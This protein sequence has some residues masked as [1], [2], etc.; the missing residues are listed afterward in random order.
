MSFK[1][2]SGF[3]LLALSCAVCGFAAGNAPAPEVYH[4]K[5]YGIYPPLEVRQTGTE[6]VVSGGTFAYTVS[7]ATGQIV[8]AEVLG[9][10]FIAA[11]SCFPNPYV[12]LMPA[13]DPGA[14]RTGGAGRARYG[15]EKAI[16]MRPALWSGGLTG[17][18]RFDAEKST[19]VATELVSSDLEAATVRSSG[20]YAWPEDGRPSALSWEI[21]YRFEVDG[22]TRVAVTLSAG[23]PVKLRWNCFNHA[24]FSRKAVAFISRYP[25]LGPPPF[26]LRPAPTQS[27]GR[28]EPGQPVLESHWNPMFH[29]GNPLTGIEFSKEDFTGRLSGYRDSGVRLEDGREIDTGTVEDAG[30]N[31]LRAHDS[32]GRRGIFTQIYVR[33]Q[34]LEL[35][36]FD[37]RNTTCPLNPGETRRSTFF[38]QLTPPK[39]PRDDLNSSRIVWPGPHQ[40]QMVRWRGRNELWSPPDDELVEQWAKVGVNLIVGGANYFSGDYSHPTFPDKVRHF[41]DTAH[42]FGMKVIPYVT[43]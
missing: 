29:L 3:L 15:F 35:E 22:F 17:A 36:E 18:Y 42:R 24:F 27:I 26:D 9:E 21:E 6:I 34:G 5:V 11:G 43:F 33:E 28:L 38:V 37:I 13:A 25:D 2:V 31:L 32:R 1:G 41:L 14:D 20:V 10:E 23:R 4:G 19:G 30:G 40:I 12:G 16:E 7:L 39:L 8:S